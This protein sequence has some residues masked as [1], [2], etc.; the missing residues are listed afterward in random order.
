MGS[1]YPPPPPLRGRGNKVIAAALEWLC[2]SGA[3]WFIFAF[4]YIAFSSLTYPFNLEWMEGQSVDIIQ[5]IMHGLPVY[6]KPSIDYVPYIYTPLYFYV[7]AL[8][9]E[10]TGIGFFPARL[11]STLSALGIGIVIYL[12]IQRKNNDWQSGIIGAGLFFATYRLS[13]RWFDN[14]R[15]DSLFL[16]LTFLSLYIFT[17]YRGRKP[18][19]LAAFVAVAAFF[20]K[21]TALFLILPMLAAGF[22]LERRDTLTMAAAMALLLAILIPLANTLSDGWFEFY[23]FTLPAGHGIEQRMLWDFWKDDII[24]P[25]W[26]LFAIAIGSLFYYTMKDWR[27]GFFYTALTIGAIAA[28]YIARLHG[29]GYINVLMPAHAI[30]ALMAGLAFAYA[31]QAN[32][33]WTISG[34]ALA[35]LWQMVSLLYNPNPLIPNKQSVEAGNHFLEEL[36]KIDGDVF[37]PELQYVQTRAG[38][39]SY[40]LG[41][42]AFDLMRSDLKNRN[43]VKQAFQVELAQAIAS[44]RFSA[45]MP[46]RLVPTPGLRQYYVQRQHL[47]YPK[48]YVTGAINFLRTDVFVRIPNANHP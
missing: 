47:T 3:N 11:V 40:S 29:Y 45:I 36:A 17:Y 1:S 2:L 28:A 41:M 34:L 16:F 37:I 38:K 8:V 20:T 6:T 12:W 44:G 13:G 18:A 22:L 24:H 43:D 15:V 48:E 31:K 25:L 19:L 10:I 46:G 23:V 42:A 5:R 7:S 30:L 21:Q 26:A 27:I 14:S 32:D 4:I 39:K 9:A 33:K 35:I